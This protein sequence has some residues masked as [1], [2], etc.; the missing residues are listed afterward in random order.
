M[1]PTET[2][3]P[4]SFLLCKSFTKE[5]RKTCLAPFLLGFFLFSLEIVALSLSSRFSSAERVVKARNC[6]SWALVTM[7]ASPN[8]LCNWFSLEPA[9]WPSSTRFELQLTRDNIS[10]PSRINSTSNFACIKSHI[11]SE[12]PCEVGRG[13]SA[14]SSKFCMRSPLHK[15]QGKR[16][17]SLNLHRKK[18]D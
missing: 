5:P 7:A 6:P 15:L 8:F 13:P 4:A 11:F 3:K 12:Q 18:A 16:A 1:A 14:N 9:T 2:F 17:H 10:K